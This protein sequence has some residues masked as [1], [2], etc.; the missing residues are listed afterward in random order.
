[1]GVAEAD[2]EGEGDESRLADRRCRLAGRS[3][4]PWPAGLRLKR[5]PHLHRTGWTGRRTIHDTSR[6]KRLFLVV[7]LEA[8]GLLDRKELGGISLISHQVYATSAL[9]PSP[10]INHGARTY[11]KG[12]IMNSRA[13]MR[14]ALRTCLLQ[15]LA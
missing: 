4:S 10:I 14:R 9:D 3:A 1:M 11:L 2:A 15:R 5:S 8:L 6:A 7:A 13:R 12:I